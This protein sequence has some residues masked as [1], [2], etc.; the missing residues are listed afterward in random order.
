MLHIRHPSPNPT[1][2]IAQPQPSE[3]P[4]I[5]VAA[6]FSVDVRM[7]MFGDMILCFFSM[8]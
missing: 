3:Q 5:A 4:V 8:L 2:D 7:A 1:H 6:A